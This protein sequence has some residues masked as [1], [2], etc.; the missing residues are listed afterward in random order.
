[1]CKKKVCVCVCVCVFECVCFRV[2][3]KVCQKILIEPNSK[4]KS[5]HAAV[6][7]A[8]SALNLVTRRLLV[9]KGHAKVAALEAA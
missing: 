6:A 9:C 7:K 1:M 2:A 3:I 5:G 4:V 8:V